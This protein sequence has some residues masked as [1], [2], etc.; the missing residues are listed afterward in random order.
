LLVF[1]ARLH[2]LEEILN[3]KEK[4]VTALQKEVRA[5]MILFRLRARG[6]REIL[7]HS[8]DGVAASNLCCTHVICPVP[9]H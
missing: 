8:M 9:M 7:R 1:Q 4:V 2:E 5:D 6:R 3:D